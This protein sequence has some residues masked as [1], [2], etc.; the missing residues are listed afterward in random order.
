MPKDSCQKVFA[1]GWLIDLFAKG[2]TRIFP[3]VSGQQGNL[4]AGVLWREIWENR[5]DP[6][7]GSEWIYLSMAEETD[8]E[9]GSL[10][11]S[12]VVI[13]SGKWDSRPWL[14]FCFYLGIRSP[15]VILWTLQEYLWTIQPSY[16][17]VLFCTKFTQRRENKKHMLPVQA[18]LSSRYGSNFTVLWVMI[19]VQV[20]DSW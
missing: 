2:K 10:H 16:D 11:D 17:W 14:L 5:K 18:S 20:G 6:E 19:L 15:L 7:E 13:A 8:E 12:K 9:Q 4:E 3:V 1:K